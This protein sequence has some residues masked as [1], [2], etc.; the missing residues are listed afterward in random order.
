MHPVEP[1][2]RGLL[3][4][5]LDFLHGPF[6]LGEEAPAR[7]VDPSVPRKAV[8]CDLC[9]GYDDYACVTACPVGAAFRIDP[10]ASLEGDVFAG[11]RGR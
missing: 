11:L 6:S 5:F 7:E 3:R 9:A 1:E 4:R 2:R 8:K 10:R